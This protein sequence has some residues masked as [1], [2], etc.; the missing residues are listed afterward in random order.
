MFAR[1]TY[2]S[3]NAPHSGLRLPAASGC[4]TSALFAAGTATMVVISA[5]GTAGVGVSLGIHKHYK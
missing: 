5:L 2:A 3:T 4:S 1:Q